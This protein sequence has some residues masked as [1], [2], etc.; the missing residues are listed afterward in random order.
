[1]RRHPAARMRTK[2]ARLGNVT[3][4]GAWNGMDMNV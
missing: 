2:G 4:M 1:M 3:G